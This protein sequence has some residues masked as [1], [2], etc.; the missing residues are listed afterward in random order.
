MRL[1]HLFKQKECI[2][3]NM[4]TAETRIRILEMAATVFAEH[5]FSGTTIRMICGRAQVNIASVNYHF[6]GKEALYR[7]VLRYVR[8]F[9]YDKYPATYGLADD[10]SPEE[11]LHAFVHSF[12]LRIFGDGGNLGFGTLTIREMVEPTGA[13]DI[14]IEEGIRSLF[15]QLLAIV[16]ALLGQDAEEGLV[17]S[18]ARCIIGQCVF[19]LSSKSVIMR[20]AP[21]HKFTPQDLSRISEEIVTFSLCAL[22]GIRN[23]TS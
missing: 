11:R 6:G 4:E 9:A 16:H 8:K 7:E 20:M 22:R 17:Q 2:I 23:R 13:L 21:E 5:G 19:Y 1:K 18:C 12:M 14:I 15:D 10:P 3:M